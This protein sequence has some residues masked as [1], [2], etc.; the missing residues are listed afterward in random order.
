MSDKLAKSPPQGLPELQQRRSMLLRR[1]RHLHERDTK[2]DG[3]D[4][5]DRALRVVWGDARFAG[6][7]CCMSSPFSF[8]STLLIHV[9]KDNALLDKDGDLND[10]GQQ[11]TGE[12]P[13]DSNNNSSA[14]ALFPVALY[15]LAAAWLCQVAVA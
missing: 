10:L 8:P 15:T 2:L 4:R 13:A 14:Q 1:H 5:L 3:R 11:H 6:C 9:L 12:D 7:E